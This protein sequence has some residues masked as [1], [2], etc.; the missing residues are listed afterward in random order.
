MQTAPCQIMVSWKPEMKLVTVST[1]AGRGRIETLFAVT[2]E[3]ARLL[4]DALL[5]ISTDK[6]G[7]KHAGA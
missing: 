5:K 6:E 1:D 7:R 4:G 3:Q 2:P